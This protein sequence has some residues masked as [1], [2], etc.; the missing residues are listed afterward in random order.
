MNI[1]V[2]VSQLQLFGLQPCTLMTL[3]ESNNLTVMFANH[4]K[5]ETIAEKFRKI[6]FISRILKIS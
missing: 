1:K 6:R 5:Q 2:I 4:L 3:L